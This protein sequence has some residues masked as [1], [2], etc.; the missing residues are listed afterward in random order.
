VAS[1]NEQLSI[2]IRPP[3][4]VYATYRRLS[5]RPWYAVAEFV[6]NSTQNYFDHKAELLNIYRGEDP[7]KLRVDIIYD[8]NENTLTIYDN[9]NGME[10]SELER[11]LVLNR[12]PPITSGRCEYGMGL[13]TAAC[14]FGDTLII[15]TS[16][17][18]SGR[19]LSARLHVPDLVA[20]REETIQVQQEPIDPLIHFTKITLMGLY[21]PIRGKTATRIKDQLSSMYRMDLR[22]GDIEIIWNGVPL[23]FQ[24]PPF[25]VETLNDG[26]QNTWRKDIRFEVPNN[27]DNMTLPVSGWVGIRIPSSQRDAGFALFRRGRVIRG[28]PGE[29]YKPEEVFGQGNSYRS[30]RIVGELNMNDWPVTQAKDDFDWS[31][32]LEEMFIQRLKHECQDYLEKAED[33]RERGGNRPVSTTDME[34]ASENTRRVFSDSRFGN[35]VAQ[36]IMLPEPTPTEVTEGEDA[37]RLRTVSQG[38]IIYRVQV[39]EDEWVFRLH[40]QD[41]ISEAHW[42]SVAY[43]EDN[44]TDIFLNIGH[45]FFAQ[46]TDDSKVLEV[47]QKFVVSLALAERM[48]RRISPDGQVDAA[49]F[50]NFMNRVLRRASELEAENV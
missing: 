41:Q 35:T 48:A 4:G 9:A 24:D 49:D 1:D 42:M 50:R 28:G 25:L 14:W 23:S 16:Q 46:Y 32:D 15:E 12:Q 18:G 43:P 29:G 2:N 30:G 20:R 11:A 6:D 31:G 34:Y 39:L 38:P 22:S 10:S 33:Y 19:K 3:V 47:L 5:Y 40:W 27:A 7:A 13:K 26:T 44:V 45:P 21:K 36:E 37:A 8:S 17:L